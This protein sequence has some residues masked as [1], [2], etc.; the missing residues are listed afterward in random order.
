MATHVWWIRRD[1]R[2]ADNQALEAAR[3]GAERLA[4]F[5]VLDTRLQASPNVGQKRLAFLLAGLR[6]LDADLRA[7]GSRLI[8]RSG[9]P[10]RILPEVTREL[11]VQAVFAE[12]DDT[13]YARSRDEAVAAQVPLHLIHGVTVFPPGSVS[14]AGG[15]S[16]VV[17][18]PFKRSWQALPPPTEQDLLPAPDRLP[19]SPAASS[20][21]I[22]STP[23]LSE[24]SP[25]L[26]GEQEAWRR[27][28]AFARGHAAAIHR[29]AEGRNRLDRDDTSELSPYLR[30]GMLSARRAVVSARKAIED[31]SG[32]EL[33]KG[34]R[35]W[36]DQLIWREFYIH[37]LA[38]YPQVLKQAFRPNMRDI[39]WVNDQE[40]FEAWKNGMTG[41]PVVDAAMRQLIQTGWMHNR[42]RMIVASF[43]VKDLLIDW[44]WGEQWF[45]QHLFDGDPACN[46]GGWQWTAG[47]GTDAAP[48]FRIFNPV[49][50]GRKHDP[51][52]EYVRRWLPELRDLPERYVHAPWEMPSETQ[53]AV[54]CIIG[55]DYPQPMVDH[56]QAR[57][58][59]LEAFSRAR[60]R[61]DAG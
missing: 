46:N 1:L 18:S 3:Q 48:Y 55:V 31:S 12:Q 43:L 13:P 9:D 59:A 15:G 36:L 5:Y 56:A 11:D 42:A 22:P 52:G 40:E 57:V 51:R 6:Q 17:Y 24:A 37:I 30:F 14:K 27:L 45:M 50:Q 38:Q 33:E 16:Y 21:P 23:L 32:S 25:F 35:T 49:L 4:V 26:P 53:R 39:E 47:T 58:H 10:R 28:E 60:S 7:R 8:V 20:D 61:A 44:R 41:Y 54:G 29:Y 34:A 2:L 19:P